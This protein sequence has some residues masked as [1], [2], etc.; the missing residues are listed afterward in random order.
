MKL[1]YRVEL[2]KDSDT[3]FGSQLKDCIIEPFFNTRDAA[4]SMLNRHDLLLSDMEDVRENKEQG[5]LSGVVYGEKGVF[6]VVVCVT[7]RKFV[8]S[9]PTLQQRLM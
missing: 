9:K 1:R 6:R 7:D 3:P 5:I 4:R 2:Y 8:P